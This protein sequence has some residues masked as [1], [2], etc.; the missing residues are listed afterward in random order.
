MTI[1]TS[2]F[3]INGVVSTDKTV[4]QNMNTLATA[5]GCWITY[6]IAEGLWSVIINRTGSSVASFNDANIIGGINVSGTGISELYNAVSVEFPHKDLRDQTDYIDLEIPSGDQFPNE[7]P[8][9][10]S[11]RLDCINNPIQAQYIGSVELKQSRMDKVIEFRTDFSKLGLKAGDLIDVTA[12]AYGY[13]NKV[14]RITKLSEDDGD[15]GSIQVSITAIEYDASIY[16]DAGLVRTIREKKTGI[17]PKAQNTAL[18][19][20]DG[21]ADTKKLTDTLL[22]PANLALLLALMAALG[23][24][25]GNGSLGIPGYGTFTLSAS[26]S[27]VQTQYRANIG[28]VS[29]FEDSGNGDAVS[30]VTLGFSLGANL[31]NLILIVQ[32]PLGL[33]DWWTKIGGSSVLRQNI[34]AYIPTLYGVY[35]DGVEVGSYTSDW[36]TQNIM[37]TIPN[38]LPGNY[39][40]TAAP[41]NTYDLNQDVDFRITPYNFTIFPQASG[42]GFT[43]TGMGFTV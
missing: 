2:T 23:K 5:A 29:S 9:T 43:V 28:T 3:R 10:L 14:F 39:T 4:L 24:G 12:S 32:S 21:E 30:L 36:Q 35:R 34:A 18:S 15:D 42:G 16:D 22:N 20:K 40:I 26:T 33:F 17:I 31:T 11:I 41:L 7:L 19:A 27:V 38:A 37:V 1:S 25:A 8:N 13:T 6:D